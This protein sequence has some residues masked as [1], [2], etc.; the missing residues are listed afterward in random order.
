MCSVWTDKQKGKESYHPG[1]LTGKGL[2]K[3]RVRNEAIW[4]PE[5]VARDIEIDE[6]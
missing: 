2:Q 1:K 5:E 6:K 3:V 4:L